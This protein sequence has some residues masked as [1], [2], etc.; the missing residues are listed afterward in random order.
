MYASIFVALAAF[1]VVYW[2][3][4]SLYENRRHAKRAEQLGCKS[5]A[6]RQHRLPLGIDL[7]WQLVQADKKQ[8]LPN[9]LLGIHKQMGK[10][11]WIQQVMGTDIIVSNEP[12]N[13]KAVL[14]TQFHDFEI[15]PQRRGNFFPMFGNGIFTADGKAWSA[16]TKNSK[17]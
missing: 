12:E 2:I 3:G 4:Y 6:R 10:A 16:F 17:K 1:S 7:V 11:S 14:A 13:I 9:E 8:M 15:G 5:P